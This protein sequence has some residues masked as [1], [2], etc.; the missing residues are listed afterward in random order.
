[1][2]LLV[3]GDST[4][5]QDTDSRELL[6]PGGSTLAE[7]QQLGGGGAAWARLS[8]RGFLRNPYLFHRAKDEDAPPPPAQPDTLA[9]HLVRIPFRAYF[10][11]R[12]LWNPSVEG[13]AQ[14][15]DSGAGPLVVPNWDL[16]R[17]TR[18]SRLYYYNP[19]RD[20]PP[21]PEPPTWQPFLVRV[22]FRGY[23]P[24]RY[25]FNTAQD[26]SAP[27]VASTF[28][29]F[30]VRVPL[31][32]YGPNP[33]LRHRAADESVAAPTFVIAWAEDVNLLIEDDGITR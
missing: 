20:L 30:L 10:R 26:L 28:A 3:P 31:R 15:D 12:Y 13:G 11:N 4:L 17:L 32:R 5:S 7:D 27:V 2:E 8:Y 9:P 24:N 19:A 6:L 16:Y 29:P 25:R 1:V 18:A 21:V 23:G 22:P 33:Y 14:L